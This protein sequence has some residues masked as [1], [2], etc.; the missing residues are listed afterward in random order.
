MFIG[1][2]AVAFAAKKV[3]PRTSLGTLLAA[4][5]FVDLIWPVFLLL[6]WERVRIEPGNT[7]FTPLAFIHYPWT[8]SLAMGF[9]WAG[10]FGAAYFAGR[11][12]IAGTLITGARVISHWLLDALVHRPDLPLTPNGSTLIG[13]GIW[14][15]IP[16]TFAIEGAM[17]V[18]ALWVY[19][20]C[21]ASKDR[22]GRYAMWS[23]IAINLIIY[24]VNPF[25]PPPPSE[26][27]LAFV[28]L[29]VW[30]FPLWAAWFDRH[31]AVR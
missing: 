14:N 10:V 16:L 12:Y 20:S 22:V 26:H 2:Y 7:V 8:H 15:S 30:I 25:G 4:A 5:L 9:V 13:F 31:R 23:F 1:H 11:R 21:T 24:V 28:A 27:A 6:G 18:A 19:L 3:A 17:F 29:G